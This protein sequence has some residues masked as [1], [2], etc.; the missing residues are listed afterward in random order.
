MPV[1]KSS[2]LQTVWDRRQWD[3]ESTCL[4]VWRRLSDSLSL[5]RHRVSARMP[6]SHSSSNITRRLTIN[7][8]VE[9][10]Y[11]KPKQSYRHAYPHWQYTCVTLTFWPPGHCML[12]KCMSTKFGV[13]SSRSFPFK[14]RTCR[15]TNKVSYATAGVN[16]KLKRDKSPVPCLSVQSSW[17]SCRSPWL[18]C[19]QRSCGRPSHT[20]SL[21]T[22]PWLVLA[23]DLQ[24]STSWCG[25]SQTQSL[26]LSPT[27]TECSCV[28][29]SVMSSHG[30]RQ[31]PRPTTTQS[32]V[33]R[34]SFVHRLQNSY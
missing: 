13:D 7:A 17:W 10:K 11:P 24:P 3:A 21:P 8:N 30:D 4:G 12:S 2:D 25:A 27:T 33:L 20:R 26:S 9:S 6:V 15:H 1:S 32:T 14:V 23:D 22:D 18:V 19:V 29:R 31:N 5:C 34:C 16:N 28:Y